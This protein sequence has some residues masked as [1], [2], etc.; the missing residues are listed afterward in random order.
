MGFKNTF[1][2]S[3][4]SGHARGVAILIANKADFQLSKQITDKEGHFVLV[5]GTK[6]T[7]EVRLKGSNIT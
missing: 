7:L 3:Y 6:E 4:A 2:S 5:K 1:Y